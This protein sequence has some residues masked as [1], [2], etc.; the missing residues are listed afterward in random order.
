MSAGDLLL[1][2]PMFALARDKTQ[3]PSTGMVR[4]RGFHARQ[5][6]IDDEPRECLMLFATADSARDYA[7]RRA[8]LAGAH[9]V[10]IADKLEL[11]TVLADCRQ[12]GVP[13]VMIATGMP[14][15]GIVR[16]SDLSRS[17]DALE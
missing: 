11:E 5:A 13:F 16:I 15:Q 1:S 7:A 6:N 10:T 3:N 14:Q 12:L 9:C 8:A 4:Y 2:F 17:L